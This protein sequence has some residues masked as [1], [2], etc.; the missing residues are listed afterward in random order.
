MTFP[1]YLLRYSLSSCPFGAHVTH[2]TS[3]CW[4]IQLRGMLFSVQGVLVHPS[5]S[6]FF[7]WEVMWFLCLQDK[8]TTGSC[9][10]VDLQ[11][12]TGGGTC[13]NS[14]PGSPKDRGTQGCRNLC[15]W[16]REFNFRSNLYNFQLKLSRLGG[17]FSAEANNLLFLIWF[18]SSSIYHELKRFLSSLGSGKG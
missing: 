17:C 12:V 13:R 16:E 11:L 6:T 1:K 7:S 14:F 2:C 15:V 3:A 10:T 8:Q 5:P 18:H 9:A 4:P